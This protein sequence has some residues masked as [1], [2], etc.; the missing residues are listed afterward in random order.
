MAHK[1]LYVFYLH[2]ISR[3]KGV[4]NGNDL[5]LGVVAHRAHHQASNAAEAVDADL[6]RPVVR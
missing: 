5:D 2:V 4:V 1:T 3:D 6:D